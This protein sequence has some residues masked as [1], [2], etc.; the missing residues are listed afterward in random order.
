MRNKKTLNQD[1]L[2]KK[3]YL[4]KIFFQNGQIVGSKQYISCN[5]ILVGNTLKIFFY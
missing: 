2:H 4:N 5:K 1:I 3:L